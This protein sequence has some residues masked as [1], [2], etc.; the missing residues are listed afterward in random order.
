MTPNTLQRRSCAPVLTP[1]VLALACC[2]SVAQAADETEVQLR[3][4]AEIAGEPFD[5]ART[6]ASIGRT[7][8]PM[9]VTDFRLYV[10]EL[11]LLRD[12]GTAVPATLD[13]DGRWQD[14]TV[15]LLDFED[16]AGRCDNGTPQTNDTVRARVPAGDYSGVQLTLGVPFEAN[17]GDP[18]LAGSPLNLTSMFWNWRGGYRF[19]KV[20]FAPADTAMPDGD[21]GH[22]SAHGSGHGAPPGAWMLHVGSTGCQSA[23]RTTAPTSCA[24]PNRV[25]LRFD[26]M[27]PD[28]DTLV[29][30]PGS[31]VAN[32]DLGSNAPDSS[33]GC[34]SFPG[35]A[36]CAAVLPRLGLGHADL[37]P[38]EQTLMTVR[39]GKQ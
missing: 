37:P 3:F 13:D 14:G 28:V 35:D 8:L 20:D 15:A 18:T 32:S 19:L 29:I 9:A 25:T 22:G 39:S 36:D 5:C 30:D 27:D 11:A 38:G 26:G 31:V 24:S 4:E 7:A 23:T 6:Y 33:P 12:D 2:A 16:G 21:T 34:M 1:A 17:H 10:S